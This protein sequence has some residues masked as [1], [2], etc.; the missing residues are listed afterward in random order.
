MSDATLRLLTSTEFFSAIA[1][2]A[3]GVIGVMIWAAATRRPFPVGG[4]VLTACIAIAVGLNSVIPVGI[5]LALILLA[6]AGITPAR[7]PFTTMAALIPGA[8][9]LVAI[10][11]S[12]AEATASGL[13][14]AAVVPLGALVAAFDDRHA[15]NTIA[16]PLL[17]ISIGSVFLTVPD[18][19]VAV[20]AAGAALLWILAGPPGRLARLGR[21][22]AFAAVGMVLWIVA[23]GGSARPMSLVAGIATLGVLVVEPIVVAM[24][25][26]RDQVS[27]P[28]PL[29]PGALM[30][31]ALTH[32]AIQAAIAIA[33]R[34]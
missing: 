4:L 7:S 2:G 9:V 13:V 18:T 16:T 27:G 23:T 32:I 10:Q 22:G 6:L 17:A 20:L 11:I 30:A 24:R 3:I 25:G 14:L 34:V 33:I 8:V 1:I 29:L 12:N 21:S 28:E 26:Q 5:V 31:L 19:E 15:S